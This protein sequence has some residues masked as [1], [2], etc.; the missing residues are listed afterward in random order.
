MMPQPSSR[1]FV[2]GHVERG[3]AANA[4][5]VVWKRVERAVRRAARRLTTDAEMRKDLVQEARV[6][7]WE[8]DPSR[9][10]LRDNTGVFYVRRVLI[11]RMWDVQRAEWARVGMGVRAAGVGLHPSLPVQGPF[12][13]TLSA[14]RR[15]A[16]IAIIAK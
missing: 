13:S 4:V 16:N 7:L 5:D 12:D 10:D 15:L 3:D 8:L 9:I 6:K 2:C 11:N 1:R 14:A